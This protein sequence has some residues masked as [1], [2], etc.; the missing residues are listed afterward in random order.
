MS[1]T[2]KG[3]GFVVI[4]AFFFGTYGIWARLME[5][6]FGDF[7]QAWT[8]GVLLLLVLIP[9]GL[10]TKSFKQIKKQD[11]KWFLLISL[12]GGINQA[13][14]YYGFAHVSIGTATLLFYL[15]LTLGSFVLGKLFFHEK[16]TGVK[17]MSFILATIGLIVIYKLA[18][19]PGQIIPAL[20]TMAAG[21]LG[22][23]FVVFSKRLSSNYSELEI[24]SI[25]VV[26][27]VVCNV[28]LSLIIGDRI[29]SF[30]N[31]SAWLAQGAYAIA[32]LLANLMVIAGYK[33]LE[34]SI[35][36]LL[37][38]LE[39]IFAAIFGVVFFHEVLSTQ[40]IIGSGFI[41]LAAALPDL[42]KLYVPSGK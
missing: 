15:M 9:L 40:L 35:G 3:S 8:R 2:L 38:L 10:M 14:Y 21:L 18:L 42:Y 26:A 30:Q 41:L 22:A 20:A 19:T 24:L 37:G 33:Y 23:T 39:V 27:V 6:S 11:I 12:A 34:P 17:Y 28:V 1:T 5:G 16:L 13:P 29:P 7:S 25:D 36:G 4:S 31:H 32:F